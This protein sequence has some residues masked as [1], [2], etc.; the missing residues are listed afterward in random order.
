MSKRKVE[1]GP[2]NRIGEATTILSDV[3]NGIIGHR[4]VEGA[5]LA[6]VL[7]QVSQGISSW[8]DPDQEWRLEDLKIRSNI[9]KPVEP[10]P[11]DFGQIRPIIPR[12]FS[13]ALRYHAEE[14]PMVGDMALI[15]WLLPNQID[16]A[17]VLQ[18]D[19]L[20]EY[21][22]SSLPKNVFMNVEKVGSL[23]QSFDDATRAK[24]PYYLSTRPWI[25]IFE[26]ESD[27]LG[28]KKEPARDILVTINALN[29]MDILRNRINEL[30]RLRDGIVGK[31]GE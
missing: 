17:A 22:R 21:D 16:L 3:Q 10:P 5:P 27:A 15:R 2:W 25:Q 9:D 7:Q 28:K 14:P 19:T 13:L 30:R 29:T 1:S 11:F 26:P 31:N 8:F 18:K 24:E 23:Y 12:M 6:R 20:G 4:T